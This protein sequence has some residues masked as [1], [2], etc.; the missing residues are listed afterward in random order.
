MKARTTFYNGIRMRS[1]LEAAYAQHLD[2]SEWIESWEYEPS[3]FA[4]ETGQY[5]PDFRVEWLWG[6]GWVEVKPPNA[7]FAA[8]MQR[9]HIINASLDSPAL[10]RIATREGEEYPF[11]YPTDCGWSQTFCTTCNPV[12]EKCQS[13][14]LRLIDTRNYEC[15]DCGW[16]AITPVNRSEKPP[17]FPAAPTN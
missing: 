6:S 16:L 13:N 1:R 14:N 11:Y 10:L 8:A 7:D 5:L 15:R 3:A 12:C 2:Q 4:S 9:M 17:L